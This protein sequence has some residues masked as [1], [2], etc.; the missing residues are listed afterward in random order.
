MNWEGF[1]RNRGRNIPDL[2]L[3]TAKKLHASI[4]SAR[5]AYVQAEIR[6]DRLPNTSV[7]GYRYT[8][9]LDSSVVK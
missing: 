5:T 6:D 4:Y 7:E 1:G 8:N 9:L 2:A 3:E